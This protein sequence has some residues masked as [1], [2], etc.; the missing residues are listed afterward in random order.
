MI[1]IDGAAGEGGGQILRT[2]LTLSLVTGQPFRIDRIRA[3]RPRPGLAPQ[4]LQAVR[5]AAAV[6]EARV[7][8]ARKGS[9]SLAFTPGRVRSGTFRFDIGTAG[10]ASLVLQTVALPLAWV[11]APSR[12]AITG[13]THVPWS[14]CFEYL[15]LQWRPFLEGMGVEV[16]LA[17]ERAG[18]YPR[19]GGRLQALLGPARLPL[20]PLD[21]AEP[22]RL[23]GIGGVSAVGRLPRSIA[24]R[25][26]RRA[27]D[28]LAR[29]RVPVEV[30][31]AEVPAPSPGT[32]LVLVGRFERSRACVSALGAR[33]KPA[34][35]V[36]DEAVEELEEVL[37]SGAPVDAHAGDQLLLPLAL[38]RGS[39][40][41]RVPRVTGHLV[42]NAWVIRQFVPQ[43]RVEIE[44]EEGR[45]GR[46]RVEG[47]ALGG[48]GLP[49]SR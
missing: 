36:A 7:E 25:Q 12:V 23:L 42:T 48:P 17:L 13:G 26:R 38:A 34:E 9:T 27:L 31:V 3:G 47:A 32:Y 8:G 40:V 6:G 45:P 21:L 15:D 39:S 28:R 43:S 29:W 49:G 20:R 5:A 19:G 37:G 35:R 44:G 41:M 46:V 4:H 24:E 11:G 16:Q 10:A 2:A 1:A 14:P 22:G 18:F 30:E 33:G